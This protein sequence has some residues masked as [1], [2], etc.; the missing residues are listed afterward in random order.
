VQDEVVLACT[1]KAQLHCAHRCQL[2]PAVLDPASQVP[3]PLRKGCAADRFG[4]HGDGLD[5]AVPALKDPGSVHQAT[6]A[7]RSVPEQQAN[8]GVSTSRS[9]SLDNAEKNKETP[10]AEQDSVVLRRHHY[11]GLHEQRH[12]VNEAPEVREHSVHTNCALLRLS[13][14]SAHLMQNSLDGSSPAAEP[15]VVGQS[16]EGSASG[17]APQAD[18]AMS[19]APALRPQTQSSGGLLHA[20]G[21]VPTARSLP[22][23]DT[24]NRRLEGYVQP[25]VA[26]VLR[27]KCDPLS[28]ELLCADSIYFPSLCR[29]F[30]L[31]IRMLE[32]L[33]Q[34]ASARWATPV[35]LTIAH[36]H[37]GTSACRQGGSMG[38][39]L[40]YEW[41]AQA[42]LQEGV[43]DGRN[44]VY[45]APTSGGK[46]LVAEILALRRLYSSG[47]P[48]LLVLPFVSLCSEKTAHWEK[49]LEPLG[50]K[51]STHMP[52]LHVQ[53]MLDADVIRCHNRGHCVCCHLC[54][55]RSKL[56][57]CTLWQREPRS[58]LECK[59]AFDLTRTAWR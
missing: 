25:A 23:S 13:E 37:C 9:L 48:T 15:L 53:A 44:F 58:R 31:W 6:L 46:S 4:N 2:G 43:M 21:D 29:L 45:C 54:V 26:Q 20:S 35:F 51:V 27:S 59:P 34:R 11:A 52:W 24:L 10:A 22:G 8:A 12:P 40:L 32:P 55:M 33:W 57:P 30:L 36:W 28:H 5:V 56:Q 19:L 42:L 41:Q 16:R 18:A 39:A 50:Y 38:N 49:I 7:G 14:G 1:A 17:G 47:K 3:K